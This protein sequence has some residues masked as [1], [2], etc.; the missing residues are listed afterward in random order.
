MFENDFGG[1]PENI[2]CDNE[3]NNKQFIDYFTSKGTHLWFSTVNQPHKNSVTERFWG[4]LARILERMRTGIKN[5][6]WAKSLPDVVENYNNTYHRS[7]K[8]TPNEIWEGK[9]ENPI[10]RKVVETVL[11]KG[12]KVRIK[13]MRTEFE[14][15]D[16]RTFSEE[17]YQIVEK[18]GRTNTIK[19]MKTGVVLKRTY[20]DEELEQTFAETPQ[21]P[22]KSERPAL[23]QGLHLEETIAKRKASR[24][25]KKPVW[26]GE[27]LELVNLR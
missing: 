6:D 25:I 18:K 23:K 7:I 2:N 1:Y 17:I 13:H 16:V 5:F 15:G 19:N 21:V 22:P 12:M 27:E 4:T 20:T 8:A 3:F 24:I 10:E 14:K 11:K 26:E 9:K